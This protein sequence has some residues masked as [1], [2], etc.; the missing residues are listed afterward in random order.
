MKHLKHVSETLAKTSEKRLKTIAKHTHH[1]DK[2]L[3]IYI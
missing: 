3:A 2:T 1:S